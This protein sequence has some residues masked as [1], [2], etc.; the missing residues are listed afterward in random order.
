LLATQRQADPDLTDAVE[1]AHHLAKAGLE[2]A[3]RAIGLLRDDELPGPEGLPALVSSFA[4]DTGTPC[5]LEVDGPERELSSEARLT[6]YRVAQ[7]ALTNVRKHAAP[8]QVE[9]H[10]S[11]EIDGTRLTVEDFGEK[12]C[13]V[14][15][16]VDK[17]YGLTGM[18]ERAKLLGG[19]LT[20]ART[21]CGFRVDLWVPA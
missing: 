12:D 8:T 9:L 1:R 15:D 6:L 19:E 21:D 5:K 2:E 3:R 7:E 17:G 4:R 13:S 11:Y 14:V 16:R 18:R 20:A 10:L